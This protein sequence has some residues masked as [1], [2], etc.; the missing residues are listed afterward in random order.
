MGVEWHT[1]LA[2]GD[3][4][5]DGQHQEIF[6][7]LQGLVDALEE[8]RRDEIPRMFEFLGDYVVQHFGAEE[9]A[10][11]SCAFPGTNVHRAAHARFVRELAD[12]RRLY[13]GTGPSF[14]IAVKAA[15]W[16]RGWLEAH[17]YGADRVF[18]RYLREAAPQ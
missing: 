3:D 7:R 17:I 9:R 8:G 12:L 6:R 10:M 15:T 4:E 2:S 18:A 13:E 14:A 11:A 16:V 1:S 5:I